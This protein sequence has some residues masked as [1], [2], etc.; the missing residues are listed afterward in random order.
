VVKV[1]RR[2]VAAKVVVRKAARVNKEAA[3]R[4]AVARVVVARVV[5]VSAAAATAKA[6]VTAN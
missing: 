4:A 1:V 3:A 5:V 6:A 2:P